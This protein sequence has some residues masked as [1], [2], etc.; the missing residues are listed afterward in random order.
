[1]V[2][3]PT[4]RFLVAIS[5]LPSNC[6]RLQGVQ[7]SGPPIFPAFGM[8]A[9]PKCAKIW[10]AVT[11]NMIGPQILA[12]AAASQGSPLLRSGLEEV[13]QFAERDRTADVV[14]LAELHASVGQQCLLLLCL[15]TFG[16]DL[17]AHLV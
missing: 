7:S 17:E 8:A 5:R 10:Q 6:C 11:Q 4:P 15:D 13:Y 2:S 16:D 12:G 3:A 1:M 9:G 14:A